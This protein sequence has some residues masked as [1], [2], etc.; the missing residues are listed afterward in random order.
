MMTVSPNPSW[1]QAVLLIQECQINCKMKGEKMGATYATTMPSP[2][3][4]Y[5]LHLSLL[6]NL[7]VPL[8]YWQQFLLMDEAHL[9]THVKCL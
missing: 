5:F 7:F 8:L 2:P 6:C 1:N 3:T 4:L 9:F